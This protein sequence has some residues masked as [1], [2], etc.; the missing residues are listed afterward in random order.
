MPTTSFPPRSLSREVD[1][2]VSQ[3]NQRDTADR[4]MPG[5]R[6][7]SCSQSSPQQREH[8]KHRAIRGDQ[9]YSRDSLVAVRAAK[10]QR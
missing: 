7:H 9:H 6:D 8:A 3:Q 4:I 10:Y 5:M 2:I 1:T